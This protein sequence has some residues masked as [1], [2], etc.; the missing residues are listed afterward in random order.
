[1]LFNVIKYLVNVSRCVCKPTSN[2]DTKRIAEISTDTKT[3][4]QRN[5]ERN[6]E[7]LHLQVQR[8]LITSLVDI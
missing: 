4:R 5:A 6:D 1:M 8:D 2:Q 3:Y 7:N